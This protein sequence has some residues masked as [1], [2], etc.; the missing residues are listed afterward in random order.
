MRI[1]PVITTVLLM[2]AFLSGGC[3]KEKKKTGPVTVA[4]KVGAVSLNTPGNELPLDAS[5]GPG[6]IVLTGGKSMVTLLFP[7]QSAVRVYENSVF[8]VSKM[9]PAGTAGDDDTEFAVER[10]KAMLI[11]SKLKKAGS[12]R[13]TTPTAVASVRGTSFTVTVKDNG[14]SVAGPATCVN[15]LSGTVQ[16]AAANRPR[17]T[18]LVGGGEMLE[19]SDTTGAMEPKAMPKKTLG[20]LEKEEAALER[21]SGMTEVTPAEQERNTA[22]AAGGKADK[23]APVLKT[24]KAIREYYHKLEEVNLDDGTTLVGAVI[25]Q[26]ASVARVHTS[27][28]IIKVPTKSIRTIRM[29]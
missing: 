26:D 19:V 7:E 8:I 14:E 18:S 9:A 23:P 4:G 10:G 3:L 16:V 22:A 21:I 29:R 20:E 12:L 5:L 1:V 28:G 27:Q 2:S 13:V 17:V 15:V 25:Y 11:I 6:D 24:E